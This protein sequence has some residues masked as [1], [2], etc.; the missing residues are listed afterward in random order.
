MAVGFH[1]GW[2]WAESF[3]FGVRDSGVVSRGRLLDS[4]I[5]GPAWMTGGAAGPEASLLTAA[6]LLLVVLLVRSGRV[7]TYRAPRTT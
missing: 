6:A 3:L 5:H 4:A 7:R 1:A 2:D